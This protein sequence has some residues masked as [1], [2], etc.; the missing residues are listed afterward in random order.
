M[1]SK[2]TQIIR[3]LLGIIL[4][5]SAINKL[6]KFIPTPADNL[7]ES[8]G[9]VDYIFPLVAVSEIIIA[10]LLLTKKWVAFALLLLVPLSLNI[11]LF[12]LYLNFQGILLAVVVITL[13]GILLYKHRR[14]Y[15]PIFK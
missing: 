7:L 11:L 15:T 8:L 3:I 14:Q 4:L 9:K 12:H 10:L 1:N 5:L 6:F 2:F 13:N